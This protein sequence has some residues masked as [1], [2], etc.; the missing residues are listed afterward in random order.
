MIKNDI[1][2]LTASE[3][4]AELA[5]GR[6]T[7]EALVSA[8][9]ARIADRDEAVGAWAHIDADRALAAA[10]ASDA[11]RASG[12]PVPALSGIPVGIKDIIDTSDFPTELGSPV[13]AGRRPSAD[14]FI[15]SELRAAGAIILGKT[16][17]TEFAFFGPGKTRN[18]H[19][20][21][22]TPGG[23]SSGSAAAVADGQVPLALGTQTAGSTIRPASY[24]GV[25][26][27]KPT[28]GY[29]SRSGVLAQSAPLDTIGGFAR[30]VEDIALLFDVIGGFDVSDRD[31]LPGPK[32]S[33]ASALREPQQ[34][35]PRF[36]FVKSPAWANADR[37]MRTAFEDF[38]GGFGARAEVVETPLPPD[39]DGSLRLQEIVQFA[40]I[41]RNYGP[42]ADANPDRV[43]AKLK[44]FVAE[45]RTFSA[46]DYAAAWA[47]REQLYEALRPILVNH[48]A[49]LTPAA[50]GP[51]L[52]GLEA[53]GSPMFNALWTYLGMPCISLPLLEVAGLPVGVQL[54][55]ARGD[56]AG[57]LR[58]AAWLMRERAPKS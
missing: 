38:A 39:F 28:F 1:E 9:L 13:F 36:A 15:V 47:E 40:D 6:L 33:L 21:E 55:G 27:F 42:I 16:V 18:P 34:H 41:A 54:T 31:M 48:D 50:P 46:A 8:C 45:G 57:L 19:H 43:S 12:Q 7:S 17:T 37:E 32:P 2:Q 23:S 5:S 3:A 30:S 51:A 25:I 20:P 53:T 10:R 56:D 26:G 35:V 14:A 24:C 29:A 49:I 52:R 44:E 22:H 11:L 4:R 58:A